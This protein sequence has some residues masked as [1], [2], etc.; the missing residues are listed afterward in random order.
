MDLH[1]GGEEDH[2]EAAAGTWKECKMPIGA[3]P[4][5][6]A[7]RPWGLW[8]AGTALLL[9][10][11]SHPPCCQHTMGSIRAP[12]SALP[13]TKPCSKTSP[14]C[15]P[16]RSVWSPCRGCTLQWMRSLQRVLTGDE[17]PQVQPHG[18]MQCF[19]GAAEGIVQEKARSHQREDDQHCAEENDADVDAR[20]DNLEQVW[21]N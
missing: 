3:V 6:T 18:A 10:V 1:L 9:G 15:P 20:R 21:K 16:S 12:C 5:G 2:D 14:S 13:C 8:A 11:G 17:A 7:R 19:V 4:A